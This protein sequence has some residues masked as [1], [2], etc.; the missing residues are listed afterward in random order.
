V[1]KRGYVWRRT[2]FESELDLTSLDL[3]RL[4][5]PTRRLK[6]EGVI[7]SDLATE[8][9]HDG[10]AGRKLFELEGSADRDVPN[11]VEP[12]EMSYH[13]YQAIILESPLFLWEGSFVAKH[14]DQY[15]GSST[16]LKSGRDEMLDQ[17]FTAVR[18]GFRGR[19]IAQA[20]KLHLARHA[21]DARA[22]LLR[23]RNDSRNAPMRGVNWKLELAKRHEWITFERSLNRRGE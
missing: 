4:E 11:I 15:V 19:G 22:K 21:R 2:A 3:G 12:R 6:E 1:A 14:G 18:P 7:I 13:D 10:E 16:L 17:G 23:T 9:V 20:V 5:P 8:M